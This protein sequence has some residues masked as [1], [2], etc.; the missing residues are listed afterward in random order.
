MF[1]NIRVQFREKTGK[2]EVSSAMF[3]NFLEKT[4]N[5]RAKDARYLSDTVL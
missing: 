5:A 3:R 2:S 1:I 4:G